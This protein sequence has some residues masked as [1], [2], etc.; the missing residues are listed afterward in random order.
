MEELIYKIAK[1]IVNNFNKI[2]KW[3]LDVIENLVGKPLPVYKTI[4]SVSN[5][6]RS[7]STSTLEYI[8]KLLGI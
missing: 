7:L 2:A 3:I 5:Y 1:F 8:G 4:T 6:L